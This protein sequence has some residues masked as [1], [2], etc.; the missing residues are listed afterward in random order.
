MTNNTQT[1]QSSLSRRT[2]HKRK[3]GFTL[4][5]VIAVLVLLGILA[6]VAVPRYVN[7]Q[8]AARD[9]AIDAGIAELNGRETLVWA[10]HMMTAGGNVVDADIFDDVNTNLGAEY[11]WAD[12]PTV[13]GGG[14]SFQGGTTATLTR[15]AA[16]GDTAAIWSR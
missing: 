5:E 7:M 12:A 11:T 1:L 8:D 9:R 10:N 6:A 16:S 3:A 4:I 15:T 2:Q 13:A 14:L